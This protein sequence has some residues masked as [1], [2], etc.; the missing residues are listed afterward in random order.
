M[1]NALLC[2]LLLLMLGCGKSGPTYRI[3]VDPLWYPLDIPQG[4]E[5]NVLGFS[6][7]LL[8]EF[9]RLKNVQLVI[10]Y[11]SWDNLLSGLEQAQYDGALSSLLPYNFNEN[12]YAFSDLYLQ[13]GPV[14]VL[15]QNS[16][17][18]SMGMLGGMEIG[19]PQG[20]QQDL[21][22]K[23]S[24]GVLA[25]PYTSV[26]QALNDILAENLDGALVGYL[27]ADGFCRDLYQ[28]ALQI[29]TPPL[30]DAGLRLI[31][32]KQGSPQIVQLFSE[33]LQEMVKDGTYSALATKWG[34]P[35]KS[36]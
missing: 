14:L 1:K 28:G 29:A 8:L 6:T 13:T 7:D 27:V 11:M 12:Q 36:G 19:F 24:P 32:L 34:L 15:P 2:A 5:V 10:V 4:K 22:L 18:T 30:N 20:S 16:P 26:P 3:G 31:S 25:R 33:A 23:P 17:V 35:V 9:S 21:L